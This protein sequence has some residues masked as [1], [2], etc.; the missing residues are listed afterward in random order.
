MKK[1]R[2]RICGRKTTTEPT[3]AMR[4]STRN[5]RK[6]PSG[7]RSVTTP[8]NAAK[9][10]SIQPMGASDQENT[11]WNMRNIRSARMIGPAT[12][13]STTESITWVI[14]RAEVS[15]TVAAL[16][17]ARARRWTASS[18][19]GMAAMS[20][21][22]CS[23]PP[24]ASASASFSASSPRRRTA[25]VGMTGTPSSRDS[26]SASRTSPSRSAMS[27]MLSAT[28]AGMPSDRSWSAKRR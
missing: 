15:E 16:E 26:A 9:P 6:K 14:R 10:S 21:A 7:N 20:G 1:K 24:T 5:E 2:T 18:S 11:A 4:P 8:C 28:T 3:P 19:V 12:G 17:I 27:T 25:T 13:W 23:A 22:R